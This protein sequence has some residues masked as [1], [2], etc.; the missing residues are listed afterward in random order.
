MTTIIINEVLLNRIIIG[1]GIFIG[2]K[3]LFYI[4]AIIID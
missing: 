4:M 3:V 1:I 2:I